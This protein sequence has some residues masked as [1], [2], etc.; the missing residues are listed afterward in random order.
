[1]KAGP[2]VLLS[3]S[4]FLPAG[5]LLAEP[6]ATVLN[7]KLCLHK[8]SVEEWDQEVSRVVEER[9]QQVDSFLAALAEASDAK[10]KARICYV[11]GVLRD[12]RA[13]PH[14]IREIALQDVQDTE[15]GGPGRLRRWGTYPARDGLVAIGYAAAAEAVTQLETEQNELRAQLL[16]S[17]IRR[18]VGED[19][20]LHLLQAR[21]EKV[22]EKAK[23]DRLQS[24][25]DY[26][27]RAQAG[28]GL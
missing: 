10:V 4:L 7:E 26:V 11:L 3:F 19:V 22:T 5:S 17:V 8:A 2:V 27:K 28:A 6:P 24:A 23:K 21:S 15:L 9:S 20:S 18:V 25:T 1:M 12:E 13:V 14:L 16:A